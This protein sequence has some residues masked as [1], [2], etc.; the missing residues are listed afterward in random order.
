MHSNSDYYNYFNQKY[1]L[2][3]ADEIIDL[4]PS[5]TIVKAYKSGVRVFRNI[6]IQNG[7]FFGENLEG[8][9]I[10]NSRIYAD[11]RNANL[12]N[13]IIKNSYLKMSDFRYTN[14]TNAHFE[15]V[16]IELTQFK[17][18]LINNFTFKNNSAFGNN[19]LQLKDFKN[20]FLKPIPKDKYYLIDLDE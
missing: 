9:I 2:P 12:K 3:K 1:D 8:I 7:S 17:N 11:F 20:L 13:A 18:T 4:T 15:N 6:E 10:E 5:E 16:N 19:N 14:L